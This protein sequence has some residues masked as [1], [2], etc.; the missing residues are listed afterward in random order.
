MQK[1]LGHISST[2]NNNNNKNKAISQKKIEKVSQVWYI[3]SQQLGNRGW[4]IRSLRPA[5]FM[6]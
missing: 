1:A 5:L 6:F 4:K 3:L 2:N